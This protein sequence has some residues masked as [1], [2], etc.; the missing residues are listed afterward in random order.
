MRAVCGFNIFAVNEVVTSTVCRIDKRVA[1]RH[2]LFLYKRVDKPGDNFVKVKVAAVESFD[3][4]L[5]DVVFEQ[6]F[7]LSEKLVFD[8][9][10]VC[11]LFKF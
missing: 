3:N 9:L 5:Y 1:V 4:A 10:S 11:G 7:D 8:G 2:I 6:P